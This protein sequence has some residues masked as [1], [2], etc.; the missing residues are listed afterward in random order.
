MQIVS[1]VF[2]FILLAGLLYA[3][4]LMLNLSLPYVQM[5]GGIDF[6]K[7]KELVYHIRHW[8]YS[9]YIHVFT[10]LFILVAGIFQFNK[11]ILKNHKR[12][13]RISGY[14]YVLD[15][16][17][18]AGPAGL[19]M[20]FYANGGTPAR[21]SFVIL[22]AL[23][24]FTT[25]MAWRQALKKKFVSHGSWMLRSYALT[26]SAITLR[27][28]AFLFGYFQIQ[29][30]PVHVYIT[31]AWLSWIPNLIIAEILIRRGYIK[32]LFRSANTT[33]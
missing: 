5:K 28:Y 19:V 16:L 32:S 27:S 24:L 29:M 31:I 17:F 6:L 13:H 3:S 2:K 12:L 22:A 10:S 23:W 33:S 15:V 26:L 7:T 21:A 18:V 11:Y 20:A 25:A 9:F 30:R 4:W 8:R 1:R 14:I